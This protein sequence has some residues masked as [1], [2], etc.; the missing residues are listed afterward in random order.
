MTHTKQP[1]DDG[2]Q[3]GQAARRDADDHAPTAGETAFLAVLTMADATNDIDDGYGTSQRSKRL[4]NRRKSRGSS[5]PS[6][7]PEEVNT[8]D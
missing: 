5:L 1:Y 2:S 8:D 3:A 4:K 7:A 6:S